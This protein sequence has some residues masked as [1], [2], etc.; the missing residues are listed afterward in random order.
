VRLSRLPPASR[1]VRE[2]ESTALSTLALV[3]LGSLCA[4][5]FVERSAP[6]GSLGR[7]AA[8]ELDRPPARDAFRLASIGAGL[9]LIATRAPRR[10]TC[11][12]HAD[13]GFFIVV[14]RHITTIVCCSSA[15]LPNL[16]SCSARS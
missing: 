14:A 3:A 8:R 1:F 15:V 12:R 2:P 16:A 10:S 13:R 5:W 11:S 4:A 9:N 6:I 7:A